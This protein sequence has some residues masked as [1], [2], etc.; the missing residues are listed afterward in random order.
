[1]DSLISD[2]SGDGDGDVRVI[3]G[4]DIRIPRSEGS[5]GS[6]PPQDGPTAGAVR[7]HIERTC[8][9]LS[10][11]VGNKHSDAS[12]S[13]RVCGPLSLSSPYP[14][15]SSTPTLRMSATDPGFTPILLTLPSLTPSLA[16]EVSSPPPPS[17]TPPNLHS[18]V[19]PAGL[20]LHRLFV[21]ADGKVRARCLYSRS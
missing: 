13:G 18:K 4:P 16:L 14:H 12:S 11:S 7:W 17:H 15:L 10:V 21:Q 5:L 9:S 20:T 2:E 6:P 19:L 8:L 1:M 3:V